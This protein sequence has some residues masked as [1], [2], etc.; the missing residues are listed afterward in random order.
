MFVI[1][2]SISMDNVYITKTSHFLPNQPISNEEME[3]YLGVICDKGS[4]AKKIVLR[5]NR[6]VNRHYTLNKS[7]E[8]THSSPELTCEAITRLFQDKTLQDGELI[9][10]G[11]PESAQF[12]YSM[13]LLRVT[14]N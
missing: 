5:N 6:I 4:R 8:A 9:L 10:L 2:W 13:A 12:Q 7:G 11:V 3:T 1:T 14:Y